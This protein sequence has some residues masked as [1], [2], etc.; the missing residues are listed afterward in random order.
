MELRLYLDPERPLSFVDVTTLP[1]AAPDAWPWLLG[2]TGLAL[3]VRTGS[4]RGRF[5]EQNPSMS[6]ELAN[7]ARQASTLLGRPLRVPAEV[8]DDDGNSQFIGLVQAIAYGTTLT[9]EIAT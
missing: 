2:A 8:F 5:S 7:D 1:A 3:S 9:L 6:V 4:L